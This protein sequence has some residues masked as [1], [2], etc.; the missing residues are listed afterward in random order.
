LK[1]GIGRAKLNFCQQLDAFLT[2][3]LSHKSVE[4]FRKL[5]VT[6]F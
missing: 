2:G 1:Q 3:Q 4:L 6:V 5:F